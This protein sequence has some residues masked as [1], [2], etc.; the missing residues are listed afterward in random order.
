MS[1]VREAMEEKE[2]WGVKG[3]LG[4]FGEIG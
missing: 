3:G 1:V 2:D 4:L